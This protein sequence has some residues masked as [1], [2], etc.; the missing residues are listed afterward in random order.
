MSGQVMQVRV[1]REAFRM[2][3]YHLL[4][5]TGS[6]RGVSQT[7]LCR[8]PVA[9]QAQFQGLNEANKQRAVQEAQVGQQAAPVDVARS[10]CWI[11]GTKRLSRRLSGIAATHPEDL[12]EKFLI[13]SLPSGSIRRSCWIARRITVSLR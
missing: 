11:S 2:Q 3:R 10:A 13:A 12:L 7:D 1:S 4:Q 5:P 8:S 6:E 9:L